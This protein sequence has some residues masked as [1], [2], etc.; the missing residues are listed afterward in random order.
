V[1]KLAIQCPIPARELDSWLF[2]F[3][4]VFP[5]SALD[6]HGLVS[7]EAETRWNRFVKETAGHISKE[8]TLGDALLLREAENYQAEAIVSWN[9]KDFH[10][11]TRIPI[12]TPADFL[13]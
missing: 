10:R 2:R 4:T 7:Q 11:R 1:K 8:M 9:A 12:H 5:V 3:T 6:A 13:R